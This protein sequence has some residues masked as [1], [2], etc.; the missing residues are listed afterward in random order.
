LSDNRSADLEQHSRFTISR[1]TTSAKVPSA[2][3]GTS[4][5]IWKKGVPNGTASTAN[6]GTAEEADR[7]HQER[8]DIER[9]PAAAVS[10]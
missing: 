6:R 8:S 10:A 2:Q 1:L 9:P 3:A 4:I 5:E 7:P